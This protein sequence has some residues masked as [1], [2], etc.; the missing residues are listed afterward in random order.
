MRRFPIGSWLWICFGW[1]PLAGQVQVRVA[2][3]QPRYLVGE[4]IF[5]V[6][7]VK[8]VGTEPVGYSGCD[9]RV[10]LA[11]PEGQEK[12]VPNLLN[13][14]SGRGGGVSG[15]G[16][17]H[18]PLMQPGET[19]S[20]R[21]LLKGYRLGAGAYD[22][23]V[24][25][26]A[27]V[28]W[29][30]YSD[31]GLNPPPRPPP[32][33]REGDPV[34]GEMFD[35]RVKLTVVDGTRE[36]LEKRYTALVEDA[37]GWDYTHNEAREAIAEMAPPFLEKTILGFTKYTD[38]SRLAVQGLAQIHSPESRQALVGLFESTKEPMIRQAIAHG[39]AEWGSAELLEFFS[40]LLRI[41][42]AG[43]EGRIGYWAA[44]GIGHIGGDQAVRALES[45]PRG[46]AP[47]VRSA[48]AIALGNTRSRLAVP[49]LI[50]LYGDTE[51]WARDSVCGALVSMTH[52]RWCSG[53]GE[54]PAEQERWRR[55]WTV[56]GATAPLYG[57]EE[58]PESPLELPLLQT[59]W[60][61]SPG[62]SI[63]SKRLR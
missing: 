43:S 27:G 18:V 22:L 45:A 14:F 17:D 29:K 35:E 51:D 6:L 19:V 63:T 59:T 52:M 46:A 36:A 40:G 60:G 31:L 42:E 62:T 34:P 50:D 1:G 38:G 5:A 20:F 39:L 13:C 53:S 10:T 23:H 12:E 49:V 30:Y 58:C 57:S 2:T 16:T 56:H 26:K 32:Q 28:R 15:C 61:P 55:W 9:G 21:S 4:P 8:N 25:G 33:H 3:D 54:V 37:A 24:S 47:E 48:V 7:S 41:P 11:V 44:L